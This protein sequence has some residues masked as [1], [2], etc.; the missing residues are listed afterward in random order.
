ISCLADSVL[1]HRIYLVW[2]SRKWI[3]PLPILTSLVINGVGLAGTIMKTKG[4]SNTA[5]E[6]NFN[7]EL[8]GIDLHIGFYYANAV[9]NSIF[10]MLI[11]ELFSI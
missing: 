3:L 5:S 10:T 11:G 7:L 8:K 9:A 1:I 6:S 2:G 4:F